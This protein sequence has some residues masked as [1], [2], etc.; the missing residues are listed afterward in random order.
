[1]TSEN[2][3]TALGELIRMLREAAGL[4]RSQLALEIGL[5]LETIRNLETGRCH[6]EPEVLKALRL[7]QSMQDLA[8]RC[9]A[10]G[11]QLDLGANGVGGKP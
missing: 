3:S 9:T 10:A 6:A 4:T 2:R 7:S 8:A 1:M 11:I 5:S